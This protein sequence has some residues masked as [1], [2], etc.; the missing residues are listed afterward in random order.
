MRIFFSATG[1]DCGELQKEHQDY[2]ANFTNIQFIPVVIEFF[3]TKVSS[4]NTVITAEEL[5]RSAHTIHNKPITWKYDKYYR[6]ATGH[7]EH[8]IPIGFIPKENNE[9]KFRVGEDGH[10]Y[11]SVKGVVWSFYSQ[12][13]I[14]VLQKKDLNGKNLFDDSKSD[15]HRKSVSCETLIDFVERSD[16]LKQIYEIEFANVT[17]LGNH[18]LPSM[19]G[20]DANFFI[21][22]TGKD[23]SV[24]MDSEYP[25]MES[26]VKIYF[27]ESFG[28]P[29]ATANGEGDKISTNNDKEDSTMDKEEM[30]AYMTEF[31]TKFAQQMTKDFAIDNLKSQ[32]SEVMEKYAKDYVKTNFSQN[33]AVS[34]PNAELV[35]KFEDQTLKLN[36]VMAK[37]SALEAT[38]QE[39]TKENEAVKA[40]LVKF[41]A[42]ADEADTNSFLATFN[43]SEEE[44][45]TWKAKLPEFDNK[46][47][48]K[49]EVQQ[50][51][52]AKFS[53]HIDQ[54]QPTGSATIGLT[55]TVDSSNAVS[56]FWAGMGK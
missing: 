20:S 14:E 40:E 13:F 42:Q 54:G 50:D 46:V 23:V 43:F 1:D 39:V 22:K 36:E 31:M 21:E 24:L 25:T 33:P 47:A 7:E 5:R 48:W 32:A 55:G 2:L 45:N 51:V 34:E 15:S 19:K 53:K 16:G 4:H 29:N 37:Y 49:Y 38:H 28:S 11:A 3:S 44:S 41:Q 8:Q 26:L 27:S 18:V 35:T 9:V 12:N 10:T 17:V 52:I 56:G 30:T 6:D